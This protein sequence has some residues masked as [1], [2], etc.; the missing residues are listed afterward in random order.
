MSD[1]TGSQTINEYE[2]EPVPPKALLGLKSYVGQF[3][4]EHVAGTELMIGPLFLASGVSAVD[5][6]FGLLVGNLLA[7]LSWTFLYCADC[8]ARATNA[9]LSTREDLWPAARDRI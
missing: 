6:V 7:V 3:A 5:F 2:R 9:L 8:H 1:Q 4:G